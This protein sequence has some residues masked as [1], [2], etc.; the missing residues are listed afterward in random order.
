MPR[1]NARSLIKDL[2]AQTGDQQLSEPMHQPVELTG[3]ASQRPY[4]APTSTEIFV[5]FEDMRRIHPPGRRSAGFPECLL[6]VGDGVR[7]MERHYREGHVHMLSAVR[8][9]CDTRFGERVAAIYTNA[10]ALGTVAWVGT[11]EQYRRAWVQMYPRPAAED[12]AAA[13]P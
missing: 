5:W 3:S 2:T 13:Q 1:R 4:V 6:P 12:Q 8:L 9:R 7:V 10:L 11:G